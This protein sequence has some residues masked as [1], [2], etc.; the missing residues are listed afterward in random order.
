MECY[1]K[2][3]IVTFDGIDIAFISLENLIE[4]KNATGRQKDVDDIR[5]LM[6]SNFD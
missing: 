3:E 5:N 1:K 6:N 2:R 4:D